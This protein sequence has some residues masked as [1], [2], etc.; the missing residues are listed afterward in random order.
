MSNQ[1]KVGIFF[2]VGLLILLAVFDFVGDI[3]FFRNEFKLRTYFDSIGELRQG[4]PVKL[5]GFDV[6]KV[7]NISVQD[8]KIEVEFAV[9][10]DIGIR[11][12][13]VASINLTSL[14]GTSYINLT[15]GTP[16]SPLA[17]EGDVLPS[18]N[19][20]DI[21]QILAKVDSAVGSIDGALSGLDVFGANKEQLSNIVNNI[22][23][24]LEDVKEGKGTIGK[25]FKDDS[26][27]NQAQSTFANVNEITTSVTEGKGTIGKLFTDES[28]YNDAKVA[29]TSLGQLSK[30]ISDSDGTLGKLINDDTLYNEATGAATHLNDILEK[31]NTG[32]GTLGQLVND[33][34]LYKDAQDTLLKVD[35]SIDTLDDLAP[36]GVLGTALGVVTLF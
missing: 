18:Q 29:L 6:G 23:I 21:N 15:F 1:V 31:I 3:P 30:K 17:V 35:K 27:Y 11:K 34:K 19:P 10:K 32:Q 12:D 28:L 33:D 26:L 5:E 14:L 20:A 13:S 36:L 7:S 22:D 8:R 2:V 25:L 4:N 24:V 9:N 16:D